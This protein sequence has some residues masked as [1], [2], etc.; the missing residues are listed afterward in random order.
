MARGG[1][2]RLVLAAAAVLIAAPATTAT[3][4]DLPPFSVSQYRTP[5]GWQ[6]RPAGSQVQ[7]SRAPAGLA[8]TPDGSTVFAVNNGMFEEGIW[9]IDASTLTAVPSP[10]PATYLGVAVGPASGG[11]ANVW[12]SGGG[13]QKVWHY[14]AAGPI[15]VPTRHV[16]L[17]PDTAIGGGANH[18]IPVIGYPGNM[19]L[20]KDGRLFV[21]GNES[22]PVAAMKKFDPQ[23]P[24][25]P[26]GATR[27]S[28]VNVV[29]VSDPLAPNPAVHVVPV[30]HDA[31]GIAFNPANQKLYVSNWADRTVSVVDA[32]SPPHPEHQVQLIP[33]GDHPTG[34]ALSPDGRELVVANA[35]ED[36]I[37]VATLGTDG[38]MTGTQTFAL[39]EAGDDPH[40]S[41][42]L[43]AA[44]SPDGSL[45]YVALA[46]INAVEVR[47][48]DGSALPRRLTLDGQDHVIPHTWIPTGWYPAALATAR[49]PGSNDM[50][51]W[52]ANLKGMGA[53]PA[54]NGDAEPFVGTRTQ[55]TVSAIDV[56]SSAGARNSQFDA[57]T[58]QVIDNNGWAY[59]FTHAKTAASDPCARAELAPGVSFSQ[60]LCDAYRGAVDPRQLHV[61]YIV[62][63]NKTFD[64]YFG[65]IKPTLPGADADPTWILYGQPVTT[66]QHEL[67]QEFTLSDDFWSDAEVSVT[68]HSF[69]SAGYATD[70]NELTWHPGY[71]Q[72]A[73]VN[74]Q[75]VPGDIDGPLNDPQERLVDEFDNPAQNPAGYSVRI[76]S[77]DVNEGSP[78]KADQIPLGYWGLS[79]SAIHHGRDLD[80]PDTDR[81]AIFL[82]GHTISHAWSLDKGGPP[83]DYGKD[84]SLSP[85]DKARFTLD[86][87]ANAYRNCTAAGADDAVCQSAMPN[88]VYMALPID[89]T[90]GFNPNTPTPP[91]MVA[92]NDYA[93]G[94]IVQAL[95]KTPFW[96]RTL[97][98][99]TE[100]DTQASGDHIDSH[101]TFLLSTGGLARRLGTKGKASHQLGSH[102]SVLKTVETM[103][104]L[105]PFT[106]YDRAAVPLHDIL[107]DSLGQADKT[108]GYT[109]VRPTVPFLYNPDD[110]STLARLS[111]AMD[112]RVDHINMSLLND[113][114][115]AGLRGWKL[116]E[117]DL[118]YLREPQ[119]ALLA[120]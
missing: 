96:K 82:H 111:Q 100:D 105:P 99:V 58:R 72:G 103:F 30:G 39:K 23:A 76:Y 17:V 3:A 117:R 78:A 42:P 29:D 79:A 41:T 53:G 52:V 84:I 38:L 4:A 59:L 46:G 62:K 80:F 8:V 22:I 112:W 110:G 88:F 20:G 40:G 102:P 7:V 5:N 48:P 86:A 15:G 87:W 101:R 90:L 69:T 61:L 70:Y 83:P 2:G 16:G 92:D 36:S 66:N 109:A 1:V 27:C 104:H 106:I 73:R 63:E 81:A 65:D 94:K 51:L 75:G 97:I 31:Y 95:S 55:G 85:L 9:G 49:R 24:A 77:D 54:F 50:R 119:N 67:A 64:Q 10:A 93:V 68:G 74:R 57:W 107:V 120:G 115:Y 71:D 18:G 91:S 14:I 113:I 28:V 33:T 25:C 60:L 118:A 26:S 11:G 34:I 47:A 89:H 114:L 37:T 116:P 108:P 12:A 13:E 45:L 35:A 56:P 43:A 19:A 98:M 6:L 32:S 21:A 44:F